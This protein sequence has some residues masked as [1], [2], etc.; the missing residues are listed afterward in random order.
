MTY[1]ERPDRVSEI[2]E[3]LSSSIAG[4]TYH[5]LETYITNLE[6]QQLI[7]ENKVQPSTTDSEHLPVWSHERVMKRRQHRQERLLKK[8][9]QQQK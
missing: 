7:P 6:S 9:R 2:L 4:E 5:M 3:K 1:I 8:L